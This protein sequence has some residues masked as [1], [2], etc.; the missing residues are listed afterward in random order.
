MST[1]CFT[2]DDYGEGQDELLEKGIALLFRSCLHSLHLPAFPCI[3]KDATRNIKGTLLA[4]IGGT[5]Y[6]L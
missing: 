4:G 5:G 1:L 3:R 6:M 2:L